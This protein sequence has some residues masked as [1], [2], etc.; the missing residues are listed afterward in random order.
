METRSCVGAGNIRVASE[1]PIVPMTFN[2]AV[3]TV[4]SNHRVDQHSALRYKRECRHVR[5][6]DVL[7][8]GQGA[9]EM[10]RLISTAKAVDVAAKA[11]DRLRPRRQWADLRA[12]QGSS[13]DR[14]AA[15]TGPG[16]GDRRPAQLTAE[17]G[18]APCRCGAP[19]RGYVPC[20]CR[21]GAQMSR[22]DAMCQ[23]HA[24]GLICMLHCSRLPDLQ[25]H[26]TAGGGGGPP[27]RRTPADPAFEDRR[28]HCAWK[29]STVTVLRRGRRGEV[30]GSPR[31]FR[32]LAGRRRTGR[33]EAT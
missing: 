9:C 17:R 10:A 22:P 27:S 4:I 33:G 13:D 16:D 20:V 18:V 8:A 2:G 14:T 21:S 23:C 32:Q 15:V 26:E 29:E 6:I 19:C 7:L 24:S 5:R 3:A 30:L 31:V 25:A 28:P 11:A 1:L 12:Q